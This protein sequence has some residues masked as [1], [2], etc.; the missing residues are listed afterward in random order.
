MEPIAPGHWFDS[1]GRKSGPDLRRNR[2][3]SARETISTHGEHASLRGELDP[4]A[5]E[6][7]PVGRGDEISR[8][9]EPPCAR[10]ATWCQPADDPSIG[11]KLR[12]HGPS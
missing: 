4:L 8:A 12:H 10:N 2:S 7:D 9:G 5:A 3:R 1:L 11:R 6:G